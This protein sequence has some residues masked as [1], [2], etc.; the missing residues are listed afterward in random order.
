MCSFYFKKSKARIGIYEYT[1]YT[2]MG[3][4]I[5]LFKKLW[6]LEIIMFLKNG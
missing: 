5:L 3:V 2:M 6:D 1:C 4:K